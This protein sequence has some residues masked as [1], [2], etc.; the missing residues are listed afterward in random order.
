M[1][2]KD[3]LEWIQIADDDIYSAQL[4]NEAF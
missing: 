2:I 1:K 4:L 3:V